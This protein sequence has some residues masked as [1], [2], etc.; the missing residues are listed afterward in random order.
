MKRVLSALLALLLAV[1]L[2][3]CDLPDF[4]MF[5]SADTEQ[6]ETVVTLDTLPDY[7]GEPY[8][9]VNG[10]QPYFTEADYTTQA[11][12]C[13]S[14]LDEL[15]RCGMAWANICIELM[16]TEEREDI[17]EVKPSGWRSAA[18]DFVD[19]GYLYNRCHL[20]GF[21]LAGENDNEKNLITGTRYMNVQ[22]MLPFEN[23]VAAY[24]EDTENHVLYRV[25]PIFEEENLLASGVLMEGWSVEDMGDGV[26]FCV[27]AYNVQPG[28]EI[29]YATG[30][31]WEA[32]T[33]IDG[34]AADYVLNTRSM[35]FH[36]PNCPSVEE[37]SPGNRQDYTGSRETL[38]AQG[39][40]PCGRC[41]P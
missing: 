34:Q 12:E 4:G 31:S 1:T 36:L 37:I 16:P 38:L 26:C 8:I 14:D 10:N 15:G 11:F 22:G 5:G 41:N 6:T 19:G 2:A 32:G 17:S 23:L 21:Q 40:T 27:Y 39:Y 30:D 20:I 25:T 29:D 33:D 24:V 7:D 9:A 28:V 13:Y 18:Y 3:G 35:K